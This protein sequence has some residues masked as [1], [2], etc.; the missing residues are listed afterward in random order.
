MNADD[1]KEAMIRAKAAEIAFNF[2]A[3]I[4]NSAIIAKRTVSWDFRD[5]L[6]ASDIIARYITY[7]IKPKKE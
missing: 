7:G 5:T 3:S 4:V 2:N 1:Y 6:D